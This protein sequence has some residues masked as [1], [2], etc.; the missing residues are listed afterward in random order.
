MPVFQ[1]DPLPNLNMERAGSSEM[2]ATYFITWCH[3]SENR[4]LNVYHFENFKSQKEEL[5]RFSNF[6]NLLCFCS[7][8]LWL[9]RELKL[10][11]IVTAAT[12]AFVLNRAL[13]HSKNMVVW[14]HMLT[15][16]N[17]INQRCPYWPRQ[18]GQQSV[19][20]IVTWHWTCV[21]ALQIT[22]PSSRQRGRPTSTNP[23]LS[24]N[25]QRE[26]GK[27]WLRVPDGCLT[28][29]P[30][31]GLTVSHNITS[32]LTT[33]STEWYNER[34]LGKMWKGEDKV[35]LKYYPNICLKQQS[36]II[37]KHQSRYLASVL[38]LAAWSNTAWGNLLAQST[39]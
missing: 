14:Y 5:F 20:R 15:K 21:I 29:R 11:L 35:F 9:I 2:L 38:R 16:Q 22:D 24:K 17:K 12:I 34:R 27:N 30:T 18:T 26:K 19:G 6:M 25:T 23:Q 32:T 7:C 37:R 3:N 4:D 10:S 8:Q 1:S 13:Y 36:K 33:E 28:S 31:G 39:Q